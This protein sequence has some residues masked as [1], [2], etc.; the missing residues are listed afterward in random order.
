LDLFVSGAEWDRMDED[1]VKSVWR[2]Q[3][4]ENAADQQ[5]KKDGWTNNARARALS[6]AVE[7]RLTYGRAEARP[8]KMDVFRLEVSEDSEGTD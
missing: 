2:F 5:A 1:E 6:L 3:R 8:G 7:G 4:R